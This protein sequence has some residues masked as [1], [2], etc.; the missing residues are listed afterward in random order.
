VGS[1]VCVLCGL[2]EL[3]IK[4]M[5]LEKIWPVADFITVHTPLT[6]DTRDLINTATLEKVGPGRGGAVVGWWMRVIG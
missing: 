1:L 6:P 4:K 5:D 3:G 2:Q